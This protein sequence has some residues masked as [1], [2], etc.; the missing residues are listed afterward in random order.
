MLY[1]V[2][3]SLIWAFSFGLIKH[4]LIGVGMDANLVVLAR[5][6]LSLLLFLPF[7]RLRGVPVT[8][9]WS[10]VGIGAVQYGVMYTL[11]L[12]S[13]RFLAAHQ[14]ALFTIFTPIYVTLIH[15]ISRRRFAR[16]FLLSALLAVAG[17]GVIVAGAEGSARG[18]LSG[19]VVL[20]GANVC[21]ALGQVW[22]RNVLV[23]WE[24]VKDRDVFGLLY[25]GAVAAT[26][27]PACLT[28]R[29][30]DLACSGVQLL[31]LLYLGLVPSGLAFFLWNAGARRVN[32]GTMAVLNNAK[33]PLAVVCS[34]VFFGEQ[35][36]W[37]PLLL[38]GGA[39]VMA[40]VVSERF[41]RARG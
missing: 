17:T 24:A 6:G 34:L 3:A 13:Y 9:R 22:Y 26:I 36:R 11:Y 21:F 37:V 39:I 30:D 8:L 31:T 5:L 40:I 33:V 16:T 2:I 19:C 28:V 12:A 38:G 32:A 4:V 7:L 29:P 1:L 15:D 35:A 14:V 27:A 18:T 10:L 25:L 20:Q 23:R 41:T